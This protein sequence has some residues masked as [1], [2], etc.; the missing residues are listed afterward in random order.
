M[1][2]H[3]AHPHRAARRLDRRLG[4]RARARGLDRSLQPGGDLAGLVRVAASFR[5]EHLL[6][7]DAVGPEIVDLLLAAAR[8]QEGLLVA[9]PARTVAE[10]LARLEA[11]ATPALGGGAA[12]V[13]PLV[14][15][16]IDLVVHVVANADGGARIVD[17]GEPKIDAGRVAAE[18]AITW[19]S[20]SGRRGGGAGKLQ[21][22]GVSARLGAALAAVGQSLPNNL[23]R[24]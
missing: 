11:L 6:V 12:S 5:A 13:A 9:M 2:A 4:R 22:T 15:S 14:C 20:D 10:G 18:S 24:R 3:G 1:R 17:V 21:V 23:V 19:R 7:A 16:T 8:G